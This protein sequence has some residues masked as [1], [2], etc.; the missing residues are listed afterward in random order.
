MLKNVRTV[1][2]IETLITKWKSVNVCP[3]QS[4]ALYERPMSVLCWIEEPIR[5][6]RGVREGIAAA[7]NVEHAVSWLK[8]E[9]DVALLIFNSLF[10]ARPF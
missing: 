7:A 3:Y 8:V 4:I 5:E 9:F 2:K 6:V 1:D 10:F